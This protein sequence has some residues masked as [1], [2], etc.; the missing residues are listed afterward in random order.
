MQ[1]WRP[2][3]VAVVE[4]PEKLGRDYVIALN[5]LSRRVDED[6]YADFLEHT[7]AVAGGNVQANTILIP[8][9]RQTGILPLPGRKGQSSAAIIM[10]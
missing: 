1:K 7:V 3:Y 10:P 9:S 2:R 8:G 4:K 6:I 5:Q